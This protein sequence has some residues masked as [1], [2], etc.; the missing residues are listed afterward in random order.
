M[1]L[2]SV[3]K[4][5]VGSVGAQVIAFLAAPVLTRLYSPDDFGSLAFFTAIASIIAIVSSG[6]YELA[7]ANPR[8]DATAG[9]LWVI[10]QT[11]NV[12]TTILCALTILI[13]LNCTD[14][15]DGHLSS[16]LW[17]FL[18]VYV[19]VAGWY[20]G[21]LYIALRLQHFGGVSLSRFS[22]AIAMVG[23][24]LLAH[25]LSFGGIGLIL[26][27]VLG[28]VSGA[29]SLRR[30]V[31]FDWSIVGSICRGRHRYML[32]G[33]RFRRF[34]IFDS[35]AALMDSMCSQLPNVLLIFLFGPTIAGFYLLAERVVALPSAFI[36]QSIGQALLGFSRDA[37]KTPAVLSRI[38]RLIFALSG[39]I[40]PAVFVINVFGESLFALVF[41]HS[42]GYAGKYAEWL[43][44]GVAVQFV[45]SPLS[46]L[47]VATNGQRLNF[48]VHFSLL[49]AKFM[50][51]VW[52]AAIRDDVAA[53]QA[54]SA[55]GAI[56]Y[57]VALCAVY[58]H[59][60]R[61]VSRHKE[62]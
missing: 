53:I 39:I 27:Q 44:F 46:V 31:N 26:G 34:A 56:G 6:R 57:T 59:V 16:S 3:M 51:L 40:V 29:I 38:R 7:I 36:G 30:F 60:R 32:V 11:L 33:R 49:V 17:W 45:Y 22:Q 35:P 12:L 8:R 42:W 10:S 52:G 18:P 14:L 2:K 5:I 41:G 50:A 58:F 28:Q 55:V 47:L 4:L 19:F 48:A 43:I 61:F 20:R 1:F 24:Q 23:S 21:N 37:V 25:M 9:L 54:L 62:I 15:V 13:I